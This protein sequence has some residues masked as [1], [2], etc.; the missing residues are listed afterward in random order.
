MM[1]CENKE[2]KKPF[3][4][5]SK[6]EDKQSAASPPQLRKLS[7]RRRTQL[8]DLPAV[9]KFILVV[10]EIFELSVPRSHGFYTR[11]PADWAQV[12]VWSSALQVII[13][14]NWQN[15][16][17]ERTGN[18]IHKDITDSNL[19]TGLKMSNANSSC[20]AAKVKL[21]LHHLSFLLN[22]LI[23]EFNMCHYC[24]AQQCALHCQ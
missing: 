7:S 5:G 15:S 18:I 24:S 14:Y 21:R 11:V 9:L 19:Q 2:Q 4:N 3:K 10:Q 17:S 8:C 20:L 12:P 16:M 22:S 23:I 13:K 1:Y 6:K